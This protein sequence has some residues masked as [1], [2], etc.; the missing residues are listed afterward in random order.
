MAYLEDGGINGS[1]FS[2]VDTG[3]TL[4]NGVPERKEYFDGGFQGY[5]FK[6]WKDENGK[7]KIEADDLTIRNSFTIFE[8]I[9]SQ[10]RA[11]KGSM[12]ITQGSAKV[13][14]VSIIDTNYVI[15]IED[16]INTIVEHDYIRCQKGNKAYHVEVESVNQN[17]IMVPLSEFDSDTDGIITNPPEAGDE[18]V[19]FGNASRLE[20]YKNRHSAIYLSIDNNEPAIDLM[21]DIYTKNWDT[22]LKVRIGGNLPGTD[23]DRGFYSVNGK[24]IAVDEEG[25]SIYEINPDGSGF[26][27]RRK[28]SWT[29][30]GSPTFSGTILLKVDN[31]NIWSVNSVG[32]NIIGDP[33][34]K[35]IVISPNSSDIKVFDKESNEILSLEGAHYNSNDFFNGGSSTI[36]IKN[37][38]YRCVLFEKGDKQEIVDIS[39]PFLISDAAS[40]IEIEPSIYILSS[41]K[42]S[43][44][45]S[46]IQLLLYTYEDEALTITK[47]ITNLFEYKLVADGSITENSKIKSKIPIGYNVIKVKS[48]VKSANPIPSSVSVS[49]DHFNSKIILDGYIS[50]LFANG[51]IMG[52]SNQNILEFINSVDDKGVSYFSSHFENLANGWWIKQN[53]LFQIKTNNHWGMPS[54]II[55]TG[56]YSTVNGAKILPQ[57]T[58]DGLQVTGSK[59][60]DR[61]ELVYP[62]QWTTL[63]I[64]ADNCICMVTPSSLE[65]NVIVNTFNI[66]YD[67]TVFTTNTTDKPIVFYFELKWI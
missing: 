45:F 2:T 47:T 7:Y 16:D 13:K 50:K 44:A 22:S 51:I 23:G 55:A 3:R 42:L 40:E 20:E 26:F 46:S 41:D 37:I 60:Q 28:F 18:I 54:N 57:R 52:T 49:I 32:D 10:I 21:T 35:R 31:D 30:S 43:E 19:Q 63:G 61:W 67:K 36:T 27:A 48:H 25:E 8:L 38:P 29:A 56:R 39:E 24:I 14:S 15:E 17:Y 66:S 33:N 4:P 12:A 5:G 53:G 64:N 59:Y 34:G 1:L 11:V 6:I 9:V 58:F 62:T 65:G